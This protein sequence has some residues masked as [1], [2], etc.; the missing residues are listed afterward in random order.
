MK[1][2]NSIDEPPYIFWIIDE[3]LLS[4][5]VSIVP[6]ESSSGDKCHYDIEGMNN[7]TAKKFFSKNFD[8]MKNAKICENSEPRSFKKTDIEVFG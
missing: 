2:Y 3:K 6:R 8:L 5:D 7:K 1:Y 4:E